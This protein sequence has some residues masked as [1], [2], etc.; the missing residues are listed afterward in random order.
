[1]SEGTPL[2]TTP[3]EPFGHLEAANRARIAHVLA[4]Q[5]PEALSLNRIIEQRTGYT[6]QIGRTMLLDVLAHLGTLASQRHLSPEQ[7]A[8][9]L[10]KVEE[11]LRRTIIEHPE[12]VVRERIIQIREL[13][14]EY[15]REAYGYRE[16]D[17][18]R[19]TPR[20]S[21]LEAMR[22]RIDDLMESVR[23]VKPD[24]TTWEESID[25]SANMSEAAHLSGEL[26]D[27]LEQCIG[28]AK[29]ITATKQQEV[30]A[31]ARSRRSNRLTA[32]GILIA[33]ALAIA[34]FFLG[35][36]SGDRAQ[37]AP[38]TQPASAHPASS[39]SSP[40]NP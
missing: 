23:R 4:D 37:P 8:T 24:E 3:T 20:H 12:E 15:Q 22:Q 31:A 18:L 36:G 33:I 39:R 6:S 14:T 2:T 10:S 1:M 19:G 25:V 17:E 34:T 13:W 9:Q 5:L 35:K 40:Q 32:L 21:D 7:Q 28:A 27:K 16:S 29:R 30:I 26:A 38:I 11:H